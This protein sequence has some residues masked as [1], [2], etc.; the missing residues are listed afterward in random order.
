[1]RRTDRNAVVPSDNVPDD[2]AQQSGED[3]VEVYGVQADH[4]PAHGLGDRC[5]EGE[6]GDEIKER[7][8]DHR[9]ARRVHAR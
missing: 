8:P 7:R 9:H 6:G 2:G 4:S 5:T 3:H 1:M